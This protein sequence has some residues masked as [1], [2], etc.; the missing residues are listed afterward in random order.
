MAVN[1][2]TGLPG[3]HRA[4]FAGRLKDEYIP[5]WED[6]VHTKRV[7]SR[8]LANKKGSMGGKRSLSS[9]MSTYPQSTGI[10]LFEGD[11]LPTTRV[12][13][14]FNPELIARTIYSR[15]RWTGHVERAA[16][17]GDS[18]AWA[19][20]RAEDLRTSRIQWELNFQRMLYLG[21][22]QIL[23]TVASI[24]VDGG[25]GG[26]DR[27]TLYAQ[28]D[29]NSQADNRHKHG[30]HYLRENMS[31]GYV[32][33][34]GSAVQAGGSLATSNAAGAV[35]EIYVT[36][37]DDTGTQPTV[38]F[39]NDFSAL[40]GA[41]ADPGDE[42]ILVPYRSRVDAPGSDGAN[43][44]SNF[45]GVNGLYN[46]VATSAVKTYVYGLSRVTY[47]SL[48]GFSVDNGS[49]GVRPFS[50]DYIAVGVDRCNTKGTG[51]EPD[52]IICNQAIRREYVKEVKGDRRFDVIIKKRGYAQLGF[53][54]NGKAL[55]IEE[56]RDCPPGDMNIL[57]S[58]GFGWFSEADLQM[59]DEGERFVDGKDAHEIVFVK[60]G[61]VMTRK[62]HNNCVIR[63]IEY[64]MSGVSAT[65]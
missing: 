26:F 52:V 55:A 31:V 57:E 11:T 61:N 47:P 50:E 32:N 6:H 63:D 48:A 22:Y 38:D 12:G 65:P 13:T 10:A 43:T 62:P 18:V 58:E 7:L 36:A 23:A 41:G 59:A 21:P 40:A 34:S 17:K 51:D 39:S 35:G 4:S 54:A 45:A 33:S 56:D 5:A 9:V 19:K 16:R 14:Y 42:S 29:R 64:A 3:Q 1:E 30:A 49:G 2:V 53:I 44:D 46:L 27:L 24:T 15:L 20:S 28:D 8:Y 37:I 60:S 25:A